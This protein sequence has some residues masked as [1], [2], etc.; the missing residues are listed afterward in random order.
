SFLP[1]AIVRV[2]L[3]HFVTYDAVEFRPG[4]YLNMVIGPNGTGKST[5]VCAIAL[6]LGWKPAVLGRAK[7]VAAYVKQGYDDGSIEIELKGPKGK[8]NLIIKRFISKRDNKSDWQLNGKKSTQKDVTAKVAELNIQ[9]E[10]L[11]SFLPQDKVADFARMAPPEL[12]KET[13]RA[14][15]EERLSEWHAKLIELGKGDRELS[16]SLDKEKSEM[17]NLQERNDVLQRDVRRYEE[18]RKIEDAIENLK[19]AIPFAKYAEIKAR[20]DECKKDR[21]ARKKELLELR[22]EQE[23]TETILEELTD[24]KEKIEL[25]RKAVEKSIE[26]DVR[27]LTKRQ[28]SIDVLVSEG[29]M[30]DTTEKLDTVK[31]RELE[32]TRHMKTLQDSIRDL[33]AGLGDESPRQET[34]ALDRSLREVKEKIRTIT[35]DNREKQTAMEEI[36]NDCRSLHRQKTEITQKLTE[37]DNVKGRRLK[38]LEQADNQAFRGVMWLRENQGMFQEKVYEPVMLELS[39]NDTRRAAAVESCI[40]WQSMR[41]FV[42]QTRADYDLF[43]REL[44]DKQKLRLNVVEQ[45]GGK[46]LS[47]HNRPCSQEKLEELGFQAFVID[48]IDG[49]EPVLNYLCSS[50]YLHTIPV[51]A[52]ERGVNAEAVEESRLFKRFIVGQTNHTISYS[53]YGNRSA[54]T[55]SR[56]LKDART[57]NVSVNVQEKRQLDERMQ[58]F[59]DK[60]KSNEKDQGKLQKELQVNQK[61]LDELEARKLEEERV[62]VQGA[63]NRWEKA[64][65]ALDTKR[66]SLKREQEKPSSAVERQKL[67]ETVV[68]LVR[69]HAS[70][71]QEVKA[72]IT[73]QVKLRAQHESL[74]LQ[75]LQHDGKVAAVRALLKAQAASHKDAERALEHGASLCDDHVRQPRA[76]LCHWGPRGIRQCSACVCSAACSHLAHCFQMDRSVQE[77]EDELIA[78]KAQLNLVS[79]VSAGVI[80]TY[81]KRKKL[82]DAL[83]KKVNEKETE[84]AR[85]E[86][87]LKKYKDRWLSALTELVS[88]VSE[89]FS[90]AFERI[91]CSGEVRISENA[92][93]D[94]WGI[95]ILVK[96]RDTEALQLLTGQRQSGGERSLSTILYLMSLTELSRSPFSLVDEINQGMDQRAE[97]A[98]HDQMVEVTCKDTA[99]QYFLITPKL[100][101]NLRFH[102]RMKVLIINNGEWLPET[103]NCECRR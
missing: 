18:R 84:K 94:L 45:E 91:G 70:V 56:G 67:K 55:L 54:Q 96:F 85:S 35:R 15:G 38:I 24:Y 92:D 36:A 23:P 58:D 101:P 80:E 52:D 69:K 57:F 51:A 78:N 81:N 50:A 34:A 29:K 27:A 97:R 95:D 3:L 63:R 53:N 64:K 31:R 100:L 74:I 6:G 65:V 28:E 5:V 83:E 32:R 86:A 68:E 89:K 46:T 14:A 11:C 60:L 76:S 21:D 61:K 8:S 62:E 79:G 42:C 72:Y 75:G 26:K 37:L 102:E 49:P 47:Q 2:K 40:N 66:V 82:I 19:V 98:V 25:R 16:E 30:S 7:D 48:L 10:N 99:S 1:G 33:Q 103:F 20:Y 88:A 12:L 44:V 73:Q 90:Q 43:T 13:Q 87:A 41:T 39:I 93:F 59:A 17:Q 9:I 77:L 4:P 71:T 22:K